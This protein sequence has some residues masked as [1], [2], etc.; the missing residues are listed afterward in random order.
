VLKASD[1]QPKMYEAP[2][3]DR[4]WQQL[5]QRLPAVLCVYLFAQNSSKN[6]MSKRQKHKMKSCHLTAGGGDAVSP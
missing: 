4:K 2:L 3:S 6:C 5:C 1:A